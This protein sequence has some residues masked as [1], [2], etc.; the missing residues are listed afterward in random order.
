MFQKNLIVWKQGDEEDKK[1]K[2]WGFQKNLIVWKHSIPTVIIINPYQVSEELNSVE[3]KRYLLKMSFVYLSRFQ[4]NLI[5]WKQVYCG[6][7]REKENEVS[8]ELN[9][10]ETWLW[11]NEKMETM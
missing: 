11:S 4:K 1:L 10:V 3:T 2:V 9:S 5:V 6:G 7:G 8:E